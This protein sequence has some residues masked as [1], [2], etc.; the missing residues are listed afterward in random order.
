MT[1]TLKGSFGYFFK[2][3]KDADSLKC[4]IYDKLKHT[5]LF[6]NEIGDYEKLS[7]KFD[8]VVVANGNLS[9][10][11]ELRI[12]QGWIRTYVR[13]AVI[14]G[15]FDPN[16]LIMWI[17]KEY[18]KNGYAY[19]CPFDRHR[20]ILAAVVSDVKEKEIDRYWAF[21]IRRKNQEYDNRGI[22]HDAQ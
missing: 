12:W 5:K 19:L 15:D 17:N 7:K 3:T 21:Y 20:A 2:Y 9:F 6:L 13:G 10:A 14:L 22:H 18:F 4:Q 8:Y 11:E 1:T 16:R